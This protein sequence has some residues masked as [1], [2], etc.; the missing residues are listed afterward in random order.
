MKSGRKRRRRKSRRK[1][2][3]RKEFY[4]HV[5]DCIEEA[6]PAAGNGRNLFVKLSF[7]IAS[8]ERLGSRVFLGNFY[9]II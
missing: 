2:K 9:E 4:I 8:L 1:R 7:I 3:R 5:Y 6:K